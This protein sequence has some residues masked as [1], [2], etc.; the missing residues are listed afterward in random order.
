MMGVHVVTWVA[1]LCYGG[2]GG[3]T[4]RTAAF[5]ALCLACM[6]GALVSQWGRDGLTAG[7]AAVGVLSGVL[8]GLAA[9]GER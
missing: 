7:L 9:R 4:V 6:V 3:F 1:G 2:G 5:V 8:A